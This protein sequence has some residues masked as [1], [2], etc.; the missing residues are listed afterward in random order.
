[1]IAARGYCR[2]RMLHR[3]L[4]CLLFDRD[5]HHRGRRRKPRGVS[6]AVDE[7]HLLVSDPNPGVRVI[8][9]SWPDER[10]VLSSPL[11]AAIAGS[12]ES[13]RDDATVRCAV[14]AGGDTVFSAG[15]DIKELSR[16]DT[17]VALLDVRPEIW[18]RIRNFPRPPI[19]AVNGFALGGC[20]EL[21]MQADIIP[22][23][24]GAKFG[25]P[26]VNLGI[27]PPA[28][29]RHDRARRRY[30]RGCAIP[31]RVYRCERNLRPRTSAED[32]TSGGSAL[33]CHIM[34]R[35]KTQWNCARVLTRAALA[36]GT[37]ERAQP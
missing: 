34:G 14:I 12:L 25:Q 22:A 31:G 15:A 35:G 20:C 37:D 10:N 26:E 23:G 2:P 36:G 16:R 32:S 8:T 9:L 11:L 1:M 18:D 33:N 30:G 5:L 21:A 6:A 4:A 29:G 24:E 28:G 3:I 13:A 19:A 27:I 17:V 7:V